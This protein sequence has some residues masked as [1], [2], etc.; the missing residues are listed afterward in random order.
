MQFL[1]VKEEN[2]NNYD[3]RC[4]RTHRDDLNFKYFIISEETLKEAFKKER[5]CICH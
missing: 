1:F 5:N 2:Q 3:E 4:R